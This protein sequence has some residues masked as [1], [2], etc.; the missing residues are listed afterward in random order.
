MTM[1]VYHIVQHDGG[2]AYKVGDSFSET[3]QT[4]NLARAAADSAA[5]EQRLSGSTVAISWEDE[6]G[7]W[8][9]EVD[10]GW[11]RPDTVIEG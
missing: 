2:W 8:H 9:E 11:D 10:E 1:L 4:H 6:N 7:E 5:R 3:F